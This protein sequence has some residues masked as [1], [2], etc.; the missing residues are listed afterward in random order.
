MSLEP[1]HLL[2]LVP[3]AALALCAGLAALYVI[4]LM[5]V[6]VAEDHYRRAE[7]IPADPP[8]V[9][10][11]GPAAALTAPV[12]GLE[13]GRGAEVLPVPA[14]RRSTGEAARGRLG[15]EAPRRKPLDREE[16]CK[17]KRPPASS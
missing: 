8:F 12:H 9:A 13:H 16:R 4:V 7:P 6:E 2:F 17:P 14:A 11:S 1:W 5:L 3:L 15:S 10:D